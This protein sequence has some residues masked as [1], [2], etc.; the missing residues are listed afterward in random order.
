M[1]TFLP[2]LAT[3]VFFISQTAYSQTAA[4]S[5]Y[6]PLGLNYS[7]TWN[8]TSPLGTS[9]LSETIMGDTIVGDKR[10]FRI[11]VFGML[12][13]FPVRNSSDTVFYFSTRDSLEHPLFIFSAPIGSS[14][15]INTTND[16]RFVCGVGS[17]IIIDGKTDSVSTPAG[18]FTNCIH[19]IH[20]TNCADA[21]WRESWFARGAGRVKTIFDNFFGSGEML[22]D[23]STVTSINET[24]ARGRRTTTLSA[25]SYPNPV[26]AGWI[27][28]A[29]IRYD[30]PVASDVHIELYDA[31][32]RLVRTLFGGH[33]QAGT[34][35]LSVST[36]SL[37]S[38]IYFY[39]IRTGSSDLTRKILLVK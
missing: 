26:P 38:G 8:M 3:G 10:Y 17:R 39:R 23:H 12:E 18:I 31:L 15:D 32:G 2:F 28:P 35:E 36:A 5:S 11:D 20:W 21:G 29:V 30:I 34:Y 19:I 33:R 1:K 16:V 27:Q 7:W 22:L 13:N 14:L 9:Q 25:Q 6:W 4:D 24:G 37:T